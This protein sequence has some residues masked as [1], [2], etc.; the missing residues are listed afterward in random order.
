MTGPSKSKRE[1]LRSGADVIVTNFESAVSMEEELRAILRQKKG[2]A[3]L[4]VDESFFI[5][6]LDAKRTLVLRRLREWCGRAYVLCGT[7]APNSPHDLVQQFNIVDFGMTFNGVT[8]PKERAAALPV[9]QNAIENRGIYIRHL[10]SD[11]LPNLPK[12]NFQ[13]VYLPLQPEQRRLYEGALK[14]LIL[15]LSSID[16]ASFQKQLL[17]FFARRSALLQI[18]SSPS[19]LTDSYLEVPAKLVALDSLLEELIVRRKEKVII[20]SFYTASINAIVERYSRYNAIRYDGKVSSIDE[21]RDAVARFQEDSETMLFVAN[22][23]AAGAG[24]TLHRA[25]YAIYES[26]SNQAAHYLQSL[27]RIHRRGQEREV[28]YI[29]L[30]CKDTI[31]IQEYQR[32]AD[33]ESSAQFL[34]GDVV[35]IPSTRDAFLKEA[36][37]ALDALVNSSR[38]NHD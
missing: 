26:M 1:V 22:P 6:S 4:A 13:R 30:L 37:E 14:D 2:R 3:V 33:K 28:E 20:W 8:L 7:P 16:E 24:L 23:A 9:V 27:D 31:E 17:S 21:R 12:K 35:E 10:K 36:S 29:V 38:G 15:D 5:K 32:L 19:S 25:R 34:L 11:V 18:C